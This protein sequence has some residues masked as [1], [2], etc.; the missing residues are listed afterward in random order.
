[1]S[2]QRKVVAGFFAV[3]PVV[4]VLMLGGGCAK[5]QAQTAKSKLDNLEQMAET[6]KQQGEM[7]TQLRSQIAALEEGRARVVSGKTPPQDA[8]VIA[9]LKET[10]AALRKSRQVLEDAELEYF[11]NAAALKQAARSLEEGN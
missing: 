7:L 10:N 4:F 1:M 9:W 8:G 3:I 11:Q 6:V 2:R 5:K